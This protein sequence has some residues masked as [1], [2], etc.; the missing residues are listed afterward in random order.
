[1]GLRVAFGGASVSSLD[2]RL[3]SLSPMVLLLLCYT[4]ASACLPQALGTPDWDFLLVT[5]GCVVGLCVMTFSCGYLIARVL[6][7]D[8]AQRAALM[9]GLGMNN[10]GTGQ[11]LAS[12]ALASQPLVLLPIITYNLSQHVAAGCVHA[13][14]RRS[15]GCSAIPRICLNSDLGS[16]QL[17]RKPR[18]WARRRVRGRRF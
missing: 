18:S 6:G 3:K 10:N 4:N 12:V 5:F 13:W 17:T 11:V 9:F 8:Q 15:H 7:T 16:C 2:E 1:M 14:L